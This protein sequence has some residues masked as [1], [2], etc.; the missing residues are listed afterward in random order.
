MSR[1][2]VIVLAAL[3]AALSCRAMETPLSELKLDGISQ[4]FGTPRVGGSLTGT[5]LRVGGVEYTDGIATHA[6][7]TWT[8]PLGGKATKL[9]AKVG[10]QDTPGPQDGS[11]EFIVRGDGRELFRSGVI[12]EREPAKAIDVDVSG[13]KSLTLEVT[14]GGDNNFSD[15]A[16]WLDAVIVHDGAPLPFAIPPSLEPR[17]DVQPT[18]HVLTSVALGL[19]PDT[20]RDCAV[21]FQA[22]MDVLRRYPGT[23][24][25]LAPG[26]YHVWRNRAPR[27][28]HFQ[29]NTDP[30]EPKSIAILVE[31]QRVEFS[32]MNRDKGLQAED[33]IAALPRR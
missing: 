28:E 27:R 11:V 22:A 4:D 19:L 9:R 5:K 1:R 16:D 32:V 15:H 14:T 24:L 17:A 31:G 13:V 26:A 7:S 6:R 23:T 21:A 30:S 12:R 18:D 8:I 3:L 29:S 20:G 25:K 33:V 10:V 2:M